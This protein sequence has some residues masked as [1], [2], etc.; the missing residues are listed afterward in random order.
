ML[1]AKRFI[2]DSSIDDLFLSGYMKLLTGG[3]HTFIGR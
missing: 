2:D 3:T 1:V